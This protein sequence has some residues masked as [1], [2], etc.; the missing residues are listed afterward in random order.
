[1][2]WNFWTVAILRNL[3]ASVSDVKHVVKAAGERTL[4][5]GLD[6][7]AMK[8]SVPD[9][10]PHVFGPPGSGSISHTYGSGSRSGSFYHSSIQ[11]KMKNGKKNL[12]SYCFVSFYLWKLWK[13][14]VP[15]KVNEENSRIRIRIRIHK[16]EAWIRGPG[17]GSTPKFHGSG[18]LMKTIRIKVWRWG[19]EVWAERTNYQA[20]VIPSDSIQFIINS[21]KG[22][23]TAVIFS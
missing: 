15:L 17:S 1:M 11:A 18:T 21:R 23:V 3:W 13:C 6:W 5:T 19:Y 2:L 12:T 4:N 22:Y 14:T 16:S 20:L 8:T 9:P 10:D 7:V